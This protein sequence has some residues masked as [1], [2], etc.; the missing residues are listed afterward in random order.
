MHLLYSLVCH[1][2]WAAKVSS[3]VLA[4]AI[5]RAA[6][7]AEQ[8]KPRGEEFRAF[9]V[10]FVAAVRANDKN[11]LADLIAFPVED[12]SVEKKGIVE[13]IG[14][15]DKSNFLA[16]YDSLFTPFMRS[17]VLEA[18]PQKLSDD[19]YMVMWQDANAEFS[20]QF[21]YVAGRGF[22]V[23]AYGIGPR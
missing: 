16:R 21:E 17:H 4:I 7:Y 9:Y 2:R 11:K 13:T 22:R 1:A 18:K 15:K 20:F 23:I 3:F 8:P 14:I 5:P 6:T 10:E 19:R 12:W